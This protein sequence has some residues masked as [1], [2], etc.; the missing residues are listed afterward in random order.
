MTPFVTLEGLRALIT[1]GTQG[2][3][4]ATIALLQELG[5][6]VLVIPLKIGC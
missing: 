1:G 4:A 2:T 6:R 3:G 5:A